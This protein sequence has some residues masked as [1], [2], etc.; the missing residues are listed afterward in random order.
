MNLSDSHKQCDGS[1]SEEGYWC[2]EETQIEV[3]FVREELSEL[4]PSAR[5]LV[6]ERT[7]LKQEAKTVGLLKVNRIK[8]KP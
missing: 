2:F 5:E 7:R 6:E 4:K 1:L 3:K 8:T